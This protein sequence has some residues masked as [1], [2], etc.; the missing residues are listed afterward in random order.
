[1]PLD[2]GAAGSLAATSLADNDL[3]EKAHAGFGS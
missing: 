2:R 1:M 3:M